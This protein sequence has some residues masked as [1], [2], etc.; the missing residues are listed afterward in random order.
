MMYF[1]LYVTNHCCAGR[2]CPTLLYLQYDSHGFR[3]IR[4]DGVFAPRMCGL[5][6]AVQEEM[7]PARCSVVFK[8]HTVA[9]CTYDALLHSLLVLNAWAQPPPPF[10]PRGF[11]VRPRGLDYQSMY[12]IGTAELACFP[13]LSNSAA[14]R[15]PRN[16]CRTEVVCG[17]A[18]FFPTSLSGSPLSDM[19]VMFWVNWY[20]LYLVY[21]CSR[22]PFSRIP[23]S[24]GPGRIVV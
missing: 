14:A 21:A 4:V 22:V 19:C 16:T 2:K 8:I 12:C 18:Y 15:I 3:P 5:I 24:Y 17:L 6:V 7:S 23:K 1:R 13:I 10:A 11:F 9:V 20:R